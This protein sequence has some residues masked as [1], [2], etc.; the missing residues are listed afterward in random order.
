MSRWSCFGQ[1]EPND[2]M[3]LRWSKLKDFP[4]C[5]SGETWYVCDS[6]SK[7]VGCCTSN[8]CFDGCPNESVQYTDSQV[9]RISELLRKREQTVAE[10]TTSYRSSPTA[11]E[12]ATAN[13][14]SSAA[15]TSTTYKTATV[16]SSPSQ[17]PSST[18]SHRSRIAL[19][20]G[21]SGGGFLLALLIGVILFFWLHTRKS[22]R[23]H[24]RTFERRISE[25]GMMQKPLVRHSIAT[26]QSMPPHA[27]SLNRVLTDASITQPFPF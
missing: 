15:T 7:F 18:L 19:I 6:G 13:I 8:P 12:T 9:E 20:A 3:S 2:T 25:P 22:R 27:S 17:T 5:S 4:L 1:P 10:A 14:P 21:T 24:Q 11:T 26:Q 16:L 23:E